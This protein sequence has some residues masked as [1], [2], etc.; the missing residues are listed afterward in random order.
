MSGYNHMTWYDL[1]EKYLV[2]IWIPVLYGWALLDQ[3]LFSIEICN[4]I[5]E[6]ERCPLEE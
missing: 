3:S 1:W 6:N 5:R 4:E 2:C